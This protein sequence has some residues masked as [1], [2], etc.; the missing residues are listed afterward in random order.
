MSVWQIDE[1]VLMTV[2][3][4]RAL[5]DFVCLFCSRVRLWALWDF[6]CL[7]CLCA[8]CVELYLFLRDRLL[9]RVIDLHMIGVEPFLS[10]LE[11]SCALSQLCWAF[12]HT[13]RTK[14]FHFERSCVC[15]FTC[16]L[17]LLDELLLLLLVLILF[18]MKNLCWVLSM[19]SSRGRLRTNGGHLSH[20]VLRIKPNA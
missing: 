4:F 2:W 5:W 8:D 7:I 16:L 11:G 3:E 20:P 12:V 19:H 1:M 13:F 10:F 17:D 15:L 14:T 9:V 6:V 18:D